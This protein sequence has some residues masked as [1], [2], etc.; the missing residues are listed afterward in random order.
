MLS[1][2]TVSVRF[3][4]M[5]VHFLCKFE[6]VQLIVHTFFFNGAYVQRVGGVAYR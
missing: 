6:T 1:A 3:R 4:H 5:E 2:D